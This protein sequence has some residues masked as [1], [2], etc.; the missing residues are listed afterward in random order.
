[1]NKTLKII[2]LLFPV[3]LISVYFYSLSAD[4]P[5]SPFSEF[6]DEVFIDID[7]VSTNTDRIG[8]VGGTQIICPER[9]TPISTNGII[10]LSSGEQVITQVPICIAGTDIHSV[11]ECGDTIV[12]SNGMVQQVRCTVIQE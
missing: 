5:F 10:T 6:N 9:Y 2:L 12:D 7:G 11:L 1:M 8:L 4:S 3:I